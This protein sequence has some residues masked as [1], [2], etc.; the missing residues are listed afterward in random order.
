MNKINYEL[1]RRGDFELSISV[2]LTDANLN[3]FSKKFKMNNGYLIYN[4][5]PRKSFI[6]KDWK[7]KEEVIFQLEIIY[8]FIEMITYIYAGMIKKDM[9]F[10]DALGALVPNN[11][12]VARHTIVLKNKFNSLK[13][14]PEFTIIEFEEVE[15]ITFY[16]NNRTPIFLKHDDCRAMIKLLSK[17]DIMTYSETLIT[18]ALLSGRVNE[19]DMKKFHQNL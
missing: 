1:F 13:M 12:E 18:N 5:Q 6:I 3:S 14:R 4:Y 11:D 9:F 16:L 17:T 8:D 15:G 2:R 10:K 19:W 7:T